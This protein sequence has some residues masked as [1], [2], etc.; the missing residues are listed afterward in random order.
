VAK[1]ITKFIKK[2]NI[3]EDD[4]LSITLIGHSAGSVVAFDFLFYLFSNSRNTCDFCKGELM[5]DLEKRKIRGNLRLRRFVTFG[6]PLSFTVFRNDKVLKILA[7]NKKLNPADYGLTT[8]GKELDGPRWINFWDKDDPISFPVEPFIDQSGNPGL[9][10]DV[11]SD[12][13]D[14]VTQAHNAYWSHS[15]IH[16][17]IARRW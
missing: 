17:E 16:E 10:Q 5:S 2:Q 11:C 3:A 7:G 12:V 4:T 8:G 6:S 9:V 1:Q 13:S 14:Y 15:D